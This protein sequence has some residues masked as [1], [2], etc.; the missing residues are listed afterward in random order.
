[1]SETRI[2]ANGTALNYSLEGREGAPVLMLSNSLGTNLHMWDWQR[3]SFARHFRLLRYDSRGHGRS[4]APQGPYSI[5]MLGRDALGLLDAL[6]I[7]RA[8]FC[9]LSKGGMVGQWLGANA[10]ERLHKL[11]LCN[12][13]AHL[14]PRELWDERI[15]AVLSGGMAPVVQ[16]V[17]DRWFTPAFQNSGARDVAKVR[18][19][20]LATPPAGYAACCMAIRDMD[21]R[22]G[23][24]RIATPTLIVVG[25][26]DPATPPPMGEAL[27]SAIAGSM[28]VSL[29]AAHL[30]NIEAAAEFTTTVLEFLTRP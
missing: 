6:G 15:A 24:S 13:S 21:Q 4:D 23:L 30:S 14:P 25:A 19:M 12:T 26:D 2:A 16:G 29:K 10:G 7:E 20:I 11:V 22:A 17:V 1:M 5:E 18:D 9:G 27:H 3:E 28:L 8:H